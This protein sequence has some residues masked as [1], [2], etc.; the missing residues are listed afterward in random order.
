MI[1]KCKNA[2]LADSTPTNV[3]VPLLNVT[4]EEAMENK[5]SGQFEAVSV[6][7]CKE[8][9]LYLCSMSHTRKRW[10]IKHLGSLKLY[11]SLSVKR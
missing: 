3:S 4:Y 1:K 10:K 9:S 5:T 2:Y 11:L 6:P 7:L 8:V